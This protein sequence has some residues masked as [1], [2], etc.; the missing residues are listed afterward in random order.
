MDWLMRTAGVGATAFVILSTLGCAH[1]VELR[2]IS[3]VGAPPSRYV[4]F[5]VL[6]ANSSGNPHIDRRLNA[7]IETA[8]AD[9]GL[10]QT[11]PEEAEAVIVVH[12][13][14]PARRS[15]DVFYQG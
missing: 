2:A 8:L 15:R 4:T 11:S 12:T 7:E 3:S 13:A 9:K 10:V 6:S 14:T 5:F 1:G